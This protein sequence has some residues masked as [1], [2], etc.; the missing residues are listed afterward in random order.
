MSKD[1]FRYDAQGPTNLGAFKLLYMSKE[2]YIDDIELRHKLVGPPSQELI[3]TTS[4]RG[5]FLVDSGS[6][7]HWV[8]VGAGEYFFC[9]EQSRK[10]ICGLD[11]WKLYW[12]D[13]MYE[14]A[15]YLPRHRVL[16]LPGG[17]KSVL[18]FDLLAKLFLSEMLW[19]RRQASAQFAALI[20][21]LNAACPD[22]AAG[23][24]DPAVAIQRV[25]DTLTKDF[26]RPYT[27][28][29]MADLAGMS[30]SVFRK[31]FLRII[32]IQPKIHYDKLRMDEALRRL[33]RGEKIKDVAEA[34]GF[35]DPFNFSRSFRRLRGLS[36][37]STRK[38]FNKVL[39]DQ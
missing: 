7:E 29:E 3:Y 19:K 30:T 2:K 1:Y 27:V 22:H 11:N 26:S 39:G 10:A 24:V 6:G 15:D 8:E 9:D 32:G 23:E 38:G 20:M 14:D 16:R 21:Q 34:V 37:R 13:F 12:F 5:K 36:P 31:Q 4:G 17:E 28:D 35:N 33:A 25:M 18:D